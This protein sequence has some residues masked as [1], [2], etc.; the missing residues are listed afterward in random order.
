MEFGLDL[1]R[2]EIW[3]TNLQDAKFIQMRGAEAFSYYK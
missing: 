2:P 3:V 1:G